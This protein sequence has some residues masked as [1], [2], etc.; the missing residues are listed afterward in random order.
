MARPVFDTFTFR[1]FRTQDP[2]LAAIDLLREV[3]HGKRLPL[4]A[5]LSFLSRQWRRHIRKGKGG[6]DA[7][8]WE[9][10][11]LLHLRD[12][13]RAGDVWVDGSRAWR[14]FEDFLLPRASFALMRTEGRLGL[15]TPDS[16]SAWGDGRAAILDARLKAL[17]AAA[18]ANT[19]PDAAMTP[20]GLTLAPIRSR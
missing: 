8:A 1:S 9:V 20:D 4:Q 3:H 17:A 13:L 6:F 5:P 15:A 18:A 19:I 10:A 12:R 14:S 7:R 2:L 16:F 11:V